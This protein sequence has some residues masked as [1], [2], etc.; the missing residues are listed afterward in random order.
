MWVVAI[1]ADAA[2]VAG[3]LI[4][5]FFVNPNDLFSLAM[6]CVAYVLVFLLLLLPIWVVGVRPGMVREPA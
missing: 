6:G 5:K 2:F 1:C 4:S 3:D